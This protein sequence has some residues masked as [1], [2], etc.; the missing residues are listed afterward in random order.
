MSPYLRY[1]FCFFIND[2]TNDIDI[3]SL[4]DTDLDLL[5][6][7]MILF[8]D[9]IVLFTTNPVSLQAQI[10]KITQFSER[11]G[12]K[13]NVSKT[14]VC[15]FETRK[16]NVYPDIFV[17]GEKIEGVDNFTYLGVKFTHTGSLSGL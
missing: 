6:K 2:I 5:S 7:Y 14:K 10:D 3:E 12:L 4:S 13:I 1:Y 11:W 15:I 16:Q 8:A 9:D 17:N